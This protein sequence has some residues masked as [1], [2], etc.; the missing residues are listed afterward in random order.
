VLVVKADLGLQPGPM[1][2]PAL[3]MPSFATLACTQVGRVL[4]L[5]LNRPERR[6][7]LSTQLLQD[8]R[9]ALRFGEESAAVGAMVL[10]G[11]GDK[12]FCAG[13]DLAPPTGTGFLQMHND[14]QK[15]ADLLLQMHACRK[16]LVG[17]AQG[18]ALA[19]GLGVLLLCDWVV[20]RDD[21]Q[22]G[23][24]EIK[25]GLFP[26]MVV[27]VLLRVLGRR[28]TLQL[29]LSG[30]PIDGHTLALWG[31]CNAAVPADQVQPQAL[32]VAQRLSALSPAILALGKQALAQ[33]EDM[34][35]AQQLEYLRAQLSINT[36]AED[37][38]IGVM[39]FF[40]KTSPQWVG[41]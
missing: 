27:A 22:Y 17:A 28:R 6:N 32:A 15:F 23:T 30:E 3:Q 7:A 11:A 1:D 16:P 40:Q 24:P 37:A 20:A 8:L 33:A 12:A 36:L 26:M 29:V 35:F 5:T 4:L 21:A 9:T 38:A 18:H 13:A 34:T 39:A 14:R 19:G 2:T 31:G 41:R 25:R 10:S